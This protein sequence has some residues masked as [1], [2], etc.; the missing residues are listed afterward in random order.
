MPCSAILS[1]CVGLAPSW[2]AGIDRLWQDPVILPK[3]LQVPYYLFVPPLTL[4]SLGLALWNPSHSLPSFHVFFVKQS[5]SS[6]PGF[7]SSPTVV[8]W[9]LQVHLSLHRLHAQS[10]S[11]IVLFFCLQRGHVP[12]VIKKKSN[13]S[14][15]ICSWSPRQGSKS[16]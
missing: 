6:S 16:L 15:M 3:L 9:R 10:N 14:K 4:R 11:L 1:R 13:Q 5:S 7:L 2:V 8:V 12:Q